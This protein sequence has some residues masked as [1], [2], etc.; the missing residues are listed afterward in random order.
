[1][2]SAPSSGTGS[3]TLNNTGDDK[4]LAWGTPVF[5]SGTLDTTLST[6]GAGGGS[7][8]NCGSFG[9]ETTFSLTADGQAFFINPAPF[10]NISFQS[11]QLNNFQPSGT[12]TINGSLD[13]VFDGAAVPEP[14]SLGLLGLGLL[15]LGAAR[16]RKQK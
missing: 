2:A 13:V 3:F 12:Q 15:G 1:V 6:C 5:G 16:R 7:G 14:A 11:G 4:L 10:Y 8:I 9:S